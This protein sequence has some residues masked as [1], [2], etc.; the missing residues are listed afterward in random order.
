MISQSLS[1]NYSFVSNK[2]DCYGWAW[3]QRRFNKLVNLFCLLSNAASNVL[4]WQ[5]SIERW[6]KKKNHFN[7]T[8]PDFTTI[9]DQSHFQLTP[10]LQ[11]L[12][13]CPSCLPQLP[14]RTRLATPISSQ[15]TRS[16]KTRKTEMKRS[17]K[18]VLFPVCFN[19]HFGTLLVLF[20]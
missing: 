10:S 15:D 7:L 1:L 17:G 18:R 11:G 2:S 16:L 12:D 19:K 3:K 9:Q 13:F 4:S 20:Q 5:N 14:R 8:A 6:R